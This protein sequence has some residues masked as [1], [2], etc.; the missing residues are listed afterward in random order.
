MLL[1]RIR[2]TGFARGLPKRKVLQDPIVNGVLK[3]AVL[4]SSGLTTSSFNK[5]P[6][7]QLALRYIWRKGWLHAQKTGDDTRYVFPTDFHR[8]DIQPLPYSSPLK[9]AEDVVKRFSPRQLSEPTRAMNRETSPL[10]DQY[11][12]EFYRCIDEVLRGRLL[13]SP[14]FVIDSGIQGG[15]LDFYISDMN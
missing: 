7:E 8:C 3:K 11:G 2:N 13:V 4:L 15:S 1:E 12:K 6:D 5:N 10:E 14:E 9:L